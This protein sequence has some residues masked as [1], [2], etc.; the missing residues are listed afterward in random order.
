MATR[1]FGRAVL[2]LAAAAGVLGGGRVAEAQ[3]RAED[4][5]ASR[6][7]RR[8]VVSFQDRKLALL[9]NDAVVLVLA[10]AVGAPETPSP[11]GTFEIV[12]RLTNP[13]YYGNGRVIEPGPSN[14]L[15]TRWIGINVKGYGLHGTDQPA[16]IGYAQSHGCIRLHNADVERLFT[17]VRS[18]DA[19][20]MHATRT[21]EVAWI[22]GN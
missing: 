15:G 18:G 16:S 11:A 17:R 8:I 14:P 21:P 3:A 19:V 4:S 5:A 20:E 12:T 1:R 9:E 6:A 13:T 10:V 2:A 22:F 7:T